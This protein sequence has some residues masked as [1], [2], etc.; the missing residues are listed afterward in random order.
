MPEQLLSDVFQSQ[1]SWGSW[2]FDPILVMVLAFTV[3]PIIIAILALAC[4]ILGRFLRGDGFNQSGI[5]PATNPLAIERQSPTAVR[6]AWYRDT[7][8]HL[9]ANAIRQFPRRHRRSARR[10]RQ[11]RLR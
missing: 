11:R 4:G 10:P 6:R 9:T 3:V 1:D 7:A 8:P 5:S 2:G